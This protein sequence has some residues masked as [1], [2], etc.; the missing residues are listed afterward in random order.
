MRRAGSAE[1]RGK[2]AIFRRFF[3]TRPP[4]RHQ[5]LR[6]INGFVF[7]DVTLGREVRLIFSGAG[8]GRM[9]VV[10]RRVLPELICY[11]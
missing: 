2:S 5:K 4:N 9:R 7:T 6:Y 11:S 8:V 3:E 10:G 1:N